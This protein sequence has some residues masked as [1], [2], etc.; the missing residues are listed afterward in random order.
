MEGQ[1]V[2]GIHLSNVFRFVKW[3]RGILGLD[4]FMEE[5]KN[6]PG[7][8][9]ADESIFVEKDWYDYDLYLKLLDAADKTCGNGDLS[10]IY[11][12]G[13]WNIHNL[14][15]LS[16]LANKPD[17]H[18]FIKG[19]IISW[20]NVYDFGGIEIPEESGNK[21]IVRYKGFPDA[22]EKCQYFRGS[23]AGMMDICGL[24][25]KVEESACNTKGAEYCEF[26][27]TW[28]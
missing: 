13:V 22:P 18:E 14:G 28:N 20:N 24:K 4:R 27:L 17:I 19:A 21:I 9:K 1:H 15:H 11:E 2:K 26:V 10:K 25:G 7:C 5:I 8:A 12:I 6:L 3:K 16:Y 23:L